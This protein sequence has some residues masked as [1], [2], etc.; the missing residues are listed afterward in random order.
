LDLKQ[1]K[2]VQKCIDFN[3]NKMKKPMSGMGF[4]LALTRQQKQNAAAETR[5]VNNIHTND[6][7]PVSPGWIKDSGGSEKRFPRKNRNIPK[8]RIG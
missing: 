3:G 8:K 6:R 4:F 1:K 7:D 5:I 2:N